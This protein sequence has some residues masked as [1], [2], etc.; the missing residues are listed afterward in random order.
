[1]VAHELFQ[2]LLQLF[3]GHFARGR[4]FRIAV[5]NKPQER[6]ETAKGCET[7]LLHRPGLVLTSGFEKALNAAKLFEHLSCD[8][9]EPV[10]AGL[11]SNAS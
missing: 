9:L 6:V 11:V 1:M 5:L 8:K 2:P 10:T 4:M 3:F 7:A